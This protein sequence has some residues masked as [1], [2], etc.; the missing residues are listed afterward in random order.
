MSADR[1]RILEL[2]EERGEQGLS[3]YEIR[4]MGLSGNPSERCRELIEDG[5]TIDAEATHRLDPHGKKRPMT[6]YTL[7]GGEAP[8]DGQASGVL[9]KPVRV[10]ECSP[11]DRAVESSGLTE[12]VGESGSSAGATPNAP[13]EP[14]RLFEVE[15][16]REGYYE[17]EAA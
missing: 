14:P 13:V 12:P 5:H 4:T 11:R 15:S 7:R 16:T 9:R 3:S 1:Q 8:N 10:E 2:L 17:R 6:I